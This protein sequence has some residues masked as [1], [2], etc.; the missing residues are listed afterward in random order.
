MEQLAYGQQHLPGAGGLAGS[1]MA[2]NGMPAGAQAQLEALLAASSQ[3]GLGGPASEFGSGAWGSATGGLGHSGLT[4]PQVT[5]RRAQGQF[6]LRPPLASLLHG[7][8]GASRATPSV[9]VC[10]PCDSRKVLEAWYTLVSQS[11]KQ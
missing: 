8:P 11:S 2:G 6:S 4:S 10:H 1:G 7:S 9:Q 5:P 3:P